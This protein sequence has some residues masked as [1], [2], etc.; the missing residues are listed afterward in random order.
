MEGAPGVVDLQVHAAD[1]RTIGTIL[2][3]TKTY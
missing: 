1:E 3:D 2:Y